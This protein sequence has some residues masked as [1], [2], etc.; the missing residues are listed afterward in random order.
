M[1]R[2]LEKMLIEVDALPEVERRRI[3]RLLEKEV[4][5]A[6]RLAPKASGRWARLAER[7]SA[8][9]KLSL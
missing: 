7:L 6:K 3:I 5:L 4:R 9:L 1:D 8:C 2:V